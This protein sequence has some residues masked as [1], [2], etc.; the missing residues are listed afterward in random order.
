MMIGIFH[1]L[2]MYI[3]EVVFGYTVKV[4][5]EHGWK[6]GALIAANPAIREKRRHNMPG[7][8]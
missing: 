7:I 1:A 4:Y 6:Q 3:D 2:K 5:K 8:C